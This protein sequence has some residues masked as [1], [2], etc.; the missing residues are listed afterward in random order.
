M[1]RRSAGLDALAPVAATARRTRRFS[2]SCV[3]SESGTT[4]LG[5]NTG[6]P[7]GPWHAV[8]N[9]RGDVSGTVIESDLAAARKRRGVFDR[10][11]ELPDVAWK[12][13]RRKPGRHRRV[14][15]RPTFRDRGHKTALGGDEPPW[16]QGSESLTLLE[17]QDWPDRC[18]P[19]WH[20]AEC[21][22]PGPAPAKSLRS[23]EAKVSEHPREFERQAAGTASAGSR[24]WSGR[25]AR[26]SG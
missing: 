15:V 14:T 12:R 22:V 24:G 26:G 7:Q 6:N 19:F 5:I 3:A 1:P 21:S 10:L 11:G 17:C 13:V 2:N 8:R 23:S 25:T 4:L 16:R 9:R 18:W 20:H